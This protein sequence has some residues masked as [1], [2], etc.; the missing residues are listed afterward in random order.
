MVLLALVLLI[1]TTPVVTL[2][3]VLV[4][5]PEIVVKPAPEVMGVKLKAPAPKLE[6]VPGRRILPLPAFRVVSSPKITPVLESPRVMRVLV[7][8]TMPLIETEEGRVTLRPPVKVKVSPPLPKVT[9]PVLRKSTSATKVLP[10]PVMLTVVAVAVVIK[11]LTVTAPVNAAD[12]PLVM[13]KSLIAT[14]TPV[15]AP[16]VPAFKPKLKELAPSVMPALKVILAPVAEP[17]ALVVSTVELAVRVTPP[18]PKLITSPEL[19]MAAPTLDGAPPV[20]DKTPSNANVSPPLPRVTAP[21]LRNSTFCTKVLPEPVMLTVVAVAAVIKSLTVTAPVNAADAPLVMVRLLMLTDVPEMALPVPAFKPKLKELAPSVMPAPKVMAAPV[22]APDVVPTVLFWVKVTAP[23][24]KLITSP[25]LVMAA[26]TLDVALPV[27][28]KPPLKVN[29]SAVALPK[30]TAPEL[31]KSTLATKELPEPVMLTVAAV[32]AVIKSLT[33]T[34]PVN[35]A[36]A[37]LVM[38][39]SLIATVVPVMAPPV[40]AFK[41][42]LKELAPSVMPAPKVMFEPADEPVVVSMVESAVNVTPPVPKLITSPELVMAAPTLDAALPKNKLPVKFKPPSKRNVSPPL[43]KVTAPVL[44]KSTL[45]TKVLL[46]PVMLTVVAVA[47]V[48]IKSLTVTAPV[49]AADA[50]LVMVK[51]L[52]ATV[53]PV[54]APPVPAFKPKLKELAPSVMPA[55]KVMFAP[56]VDPM[57]SKL[58][59]VEAAVSVTPP[60]PKL[61][62]SPLLVMAAPKLDVALPVKAKPPSKRNVSTVALP[63]VTAPELRKSTLATKV[64]PEPVMEMV[65]AVAAV[66]RSLTVTAPV[67]AAEAP[68]VMVRLLMLTDVP[69][70]APPVPAFKPK[71]K[72]APLMPALK[73][74]FAPVAKPPAFVVSIVTAAVFK[75][76]VLLKITASPDVVI[77]TPSIFA[78]L[79]TV[80][81]LL[82]EELAILKVTPVPP[83]VNVVIPVMVPPPE[84]AFTVIVPDPAAVIFNEP[85]AVI[86]SSSASVRLNPVPAVPKSTLE[87]LVIPMA[88]VTLIAAPIET[89]AALVMI[90]AE[91]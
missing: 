75:V 21:V 81:A 5:G 13:V 33:V 65:V 89:S 87:L 83:A 38:V 64:L 60:V 44:R 40:P 41:P 71:F 47:A 80:N 1:F 12:R 66:I 39:K 48:V 6:T 79:A 90:S 76:T 49:N 70:M 57:A 23:V 8:A 74:M 22:A 52:I 19:V 85:A 17:P 55:P 34:A 36:D 88:P 25:E 2:V 9:A 51:S 26:P 42:K 91:S 54:M 37:P 61:I 69:V 43:P 10:V 53:V 20:K 35:A 24:P 31:R 18:V 15:M 50:P 11:S 46:V 82:N 3:V 78:A 29:V 73:V 59:K 14:V 63:K 84:T 86:K 77:F 68:L 45:A 28:A 72:A 16:P 67:N 58:A 4:L 7:V 27:K 62:T 56:A 32:A 30:V